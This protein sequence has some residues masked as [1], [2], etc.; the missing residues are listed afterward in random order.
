MLV[1]G[2]H[3]DEAHVSLRHVCFVVNNDGVYILGMRDGTEF[4]VTSGSY[5]E[6][7]RAIDG[8]DRMEG[9]ED[10]EV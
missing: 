6:L 1:K 2:Y 3:F 4:E 7:A 8:I 9:A 10:A 5:K